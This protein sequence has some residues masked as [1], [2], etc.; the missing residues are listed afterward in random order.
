MTAKGRG[1]GLA[2]LAIACSA[3]HPVAEQQP[4]F[5]PPTAPTPEAAPP[6]DTS[7]WARAD[8]S[9]FARDVSWP[10]TDGEQCLADLGCP[11]A[12]AIPPCRSIPAAESLERALAA[13]L[14]GEGRRAVLQARLAAATPITQRGCGWGC[15][16]TRGGGLVLVQ[17][18]HTVAL[19]APPGSR[20]FACGGDDSVECCGF[21]LPEGNVVA[22]GVLRMEEGRPVLEDVA[23]CDRSPEPAPPDA[24]FSSTA[25][26]VAGRAHAFGRPFVHERRI[27]VC[28]ASS[29]SCRG[30]GCFHAGRWFPLGFRLRRSDCGTCTCEGAWRCPSEPCWESGP[31]VDFETGRAELSPH[32]RQSLALMS[33]L[34]H[35][36]GRIEVSGWAAAG[37]APEVALR[38]ARAV[39]AALI[40][41]GTRPEQLFL[42]ARE[43]PGP[44]KDGKRASLTFWS[45]ERPSVPPE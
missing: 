35:F 13:P 33:G 21:A 34:Q 23:L 6:V 28:D 44:S 37:E 30:Q 10:S 19:R 26:T 32:A 5:T 31:V 40:G 41:L 27:C 8:S 43:S 12:A 1:V 22:A 7:G 39:K 36:G 24:S 11:R 45:S 14:P 17:A 38:R 15:C 18:D 3:R 42:S 29:I 25:C 16:N 2:L 9:S 4:S 20:A